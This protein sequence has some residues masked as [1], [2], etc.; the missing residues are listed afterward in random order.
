MYWAQKLEESGGNLE[1]IVYEFSESPV[2]LELYG[3][4]PVE[5][6]IKEIYPSVFNREPGEEGLNFYREKVERG[7]TKLA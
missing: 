5:G 2:A 7:E 6:V 4:K 1:A 3:N